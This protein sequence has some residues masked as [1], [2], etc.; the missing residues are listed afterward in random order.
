[1]G[2]CQVVANS[3]DDK[4]TEAL[5]VCFFV[6]LCHGFLIVHLAVNLPEPEPDGERLSF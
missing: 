6:A 1:M 4:S 2:C 3:L 5:A